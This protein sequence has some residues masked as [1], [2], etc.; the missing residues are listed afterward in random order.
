MHAPKASA[1]GA[2]GQSFVGFVALIA[3]LMA[4]TSLAVDAMLPALPQIGEALGITDDNQR[5]WIVTAYLL[6]FG[7]VQIFIGP[8]ADRFGRRPLILGGL[9]LYGFSAVAS[10]LAGSF[11][12]MMVARMLQGIGAA[13]PR[14][15]AATVVRDGHSGR[16]M[17]RVMSLAM[18]TFLA[19]PVLAPSIGQLVLFVAP[20]RAIFA[21]FAIFALIVFAWA[22]VALPETLRPENRSNLHAGTIARNMAACF[23]E[24]AALGYM[25][26]MGCAMGGLLAFINSVQQICADVFDAAAWMPLVMAFVG[27]SM[28]AASLFNSRIVGRLGMRVTSHAAA[29]AFLAG[30]IVHVA[31]AASGHESLVGFTLVQCFVMFSFGFMVPNF[32]AM[33]MEPLGRLAGTGS[34]VQGFTTTLLGALIGFAI[35]QEFDGTLLPYGVGVTLCAGGVL[36]SALI[37]EDGRLFR[38]AHR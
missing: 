4:I 12:P 23:R 25:L 15:L 7:V 33:A 35:G 13:A 24:R 9:A 10:A 5:Q 37:A 22:F 27:S 14:V 20:W 38:A 31:L 34:A 19:V 21:V 30:G 26:A 1:T 17:A 32:G 36:G 8:L 2:T 11:A 18:M 6:G 29:F 28:A 3:A 16:E